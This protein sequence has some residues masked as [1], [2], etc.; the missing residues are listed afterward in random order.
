M[1]E[2][3]WQT[4]KY[5]KPEEFD[6]PDKTGSGATCM[7]LEFIKLLE[8]IRFQCNFPFKITSGYRS[9]ERNVVVG[10]KENSAHL[11]GNAVDIRFN[12]SS[13]LY[14]IVFYSMQNGIKRLGISFNSSFIHIDN[15]LVLPQNVIWRYPY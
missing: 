5:F 7:N 11:R 10:G 9:P 12:N 4:V 1:I 2:Q 14:S 8:K 6:S 3:D 13:E 15:D